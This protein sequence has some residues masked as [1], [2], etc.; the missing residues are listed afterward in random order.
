M[1]YDVKGRNRKASMMMASVTQSLD[2]LSTLSA[3]QS[4]V[5]KTWR[6]GGGEHR[7]GRGA[8]APPVC[9]LKRP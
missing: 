1:F 6:G 7:A 5:I 9:M 4:D 3:R 2:E 8:L